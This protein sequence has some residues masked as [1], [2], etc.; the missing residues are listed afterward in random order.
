M[1]PVQLIDLLTATHGQ[2]AGI[3]D[4]RLVFAQVSVDSRTLQ[5]GAL[6]WALRG[7]SARLLSNASAARLVRPKLNS[8]SAKRI[9]AAPNAG[10]LVVASRTASRA[11]A[12]FPRDCC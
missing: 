1:E 4:E 3:E 11:A 2:S 12:S 6:F 8:S 10:D 9:Q 7:A 5:P